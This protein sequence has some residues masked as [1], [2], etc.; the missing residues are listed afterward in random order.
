MVSTD[1][2]TLEGL[3][4]LFERAGFEA[5]ATRTIDVAL[6]YRDFDDFWDAQTPNFSP[7][8]KTIMAFAGADRA[9]LIET[10]RASLPPAPDGSISCSA[11]AN[12]INA[13]VPRMTLATDSARRHSF[14]S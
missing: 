2:S 10:V 4:G 9:R 14:W 12:A 1:D 11:R 6:A 7:L 5:I 8:T 13:T 3:K